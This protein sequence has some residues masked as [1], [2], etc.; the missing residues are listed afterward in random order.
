MNAMMMSSKPMIIA[1][2]HKRDVF[3]ALPNIGF[4][5]TTSLLSCVPVCTGPEDATEITICCLADESW[6]STSCD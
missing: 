6:P 4:N 1:I 5:F 3:S 2:V